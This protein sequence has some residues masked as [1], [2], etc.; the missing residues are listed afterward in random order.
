MK[1]ATSTIQK[2]F[3]TGGAQASGALRPEPAAGGSPAGFSPSEI[4]RALP[5]KWKR[6]RD[7]W[8]QLSEGRFAAIIHTGSS[9]QSNILIHGAS[10]EEVLAVTELILDA[11]ARAVNGGAR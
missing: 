1:A 8:R 11:A 10:R 4:S 7:P 3:T 5:R 2:T 6:G 9:P